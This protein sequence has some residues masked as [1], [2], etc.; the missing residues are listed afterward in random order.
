MSAGSKGRALRDPT[1]LVKHPAGVPH[2]L[3]TRD[4][5]KDSLVPASTKVGDNTQK[6][7]KEEGRWKEGMSQGVYKLDETGAGNRRHLGR[8][9][10]L[11]RWGDRSTLCG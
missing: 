3:Q 2:F 1:L 11:R 5:G 9:E 4:P 7:R 6:T 10:T 8:E